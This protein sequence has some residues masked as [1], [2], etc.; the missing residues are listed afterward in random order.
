MERLLKSHKKNHCKQ[1]N[2]E[3]K[4][5]DALQQ[6]NSTFFL[7]K[8]NNVKYS[9]LPSLLVETQWPLFQFK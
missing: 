8:L 9:L 5:K 3:S 1:N 4:I 7:V 2:C 6:N